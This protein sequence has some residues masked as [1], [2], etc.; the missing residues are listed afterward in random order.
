M[1]KHILF[2]AM[3]LATLPMTAQETY[4]NAKLLGEDLNGTARYV[5]MGGA[6]EALGADI[7]TIS[8]NPAGIGL[9]RRSAVS[10]S[11]GLKMQGGNQS[12]DGQSKTTA[13]FDQIGFVISTQTRRNS[14]LNFSFNFHKGKN[15]NQILSASNR[16]NSGSSQNLSFQKGA[17]GNV[18][19]GGF[20]PALDKNNEYIGYENPKSD[21]TAQTFSQTDYLNWNVFI[22]TKVGTEDVFGYCDASDYTFGRKT[23]GYIGN[24]DFNVSGNIHDIV[25]LGID[26]GI[27]DVRY[28]DY[29]IYDE[30]LVSNGAADGNATY[31]DERQIR[32]T[33]FDVALGVIV[34]PIENS[35]FR[36]G[37]SVKTPT[38]YNLTTENYTTV[39]NT[40]KSGLYDN[41]KIREAYDFK[42]YTPWKFGVSLGHTVGNYL[43]LGASF[44]YE[45][46]GAADTRIN[47][48][49]IVDGRGAFE[50]NSRDRVMK[51]HTERTL[52][53]VSTFK[54]GAE[55]KAAPE[56]AIRVG[57]NYVSPA[58]N[59]N[60]QKDM[61]LESPGT[62]YASATDF[63]N[64]KATNRFTCGIG[65]AKKGFHADLAFQ[66]AA[67]KGDFYPFQSLE[68]TYTDADNATQTA[69]CNPGATEVTNNRSQL[70]LTVGY[71][72]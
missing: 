49:V 66:Y 41:G 12:F 53:G 58:Y 50:T 9:F 51:A 20:D 59:S 67:Q 43:A 29:S 19:N 23:S 22:P 17:R 63:T 30:A 31:S 70:L 69:V 21:R 44:D 26:F 34:R 25:Y 13:S 1:K 35:P 10:A 54:V 65:Y 55:I 11:F 60:A 6:M 42:L 7:S 18:S 37:V 52:K 39:K 36:F 33:G 57:Y 24:Y 56:V 3:S 5:G 47:D 28:K 38:W 14:F 27:K 4:E 15:F 40:S 71:R 16:I 8:S 32:G 2:A 64:W 46:Y 68:T 62:Y 48:G 72:F 45:D 61:T